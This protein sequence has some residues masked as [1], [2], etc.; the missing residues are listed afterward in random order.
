MVYF[1]AWWKSRRKS[2]NEP[3]S[4]HPIGKRIETHEGSLAA[5]VDLH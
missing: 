5:T 4:V 3:P 2:L 1:V